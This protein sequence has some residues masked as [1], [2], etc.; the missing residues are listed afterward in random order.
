MKAILFSLTILTLASTASAQKNRQGTPSASKENVKFLEDISI[1]VGPS[2][3]VYTI[4]NSRPAN[5]QTQGFETRTAGI[6]IEHSNPLQ[7]KY[8]VL[9]DTRVE[10][11]HNLDLFQQIDNW[12]GVAYRMGG[13]DHDGIDCSAFTQTL[14]SAVY[15][16]SIPRTAR[17][18]FDACTPVQREELKE[19]DLVFFN[20]GGGVSHVGFFLQGSKFVHASSSG[21]MI[22]DLNENYWSSHFLNGGRLN[23]SAAVVPVPVSAR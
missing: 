9:M 21:V 19:G 7:F 20:T 13:T 11:I 14:Y 4:T 3:A 5:N 2:Q 23:D 12:Y 6:D 16:R 8:A 15:N 22:S 17:E 10:D 18:Q 1:E